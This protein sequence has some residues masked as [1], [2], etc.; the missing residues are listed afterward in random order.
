MSSRLATENVV[1]T[2]TL[3]AG[4]G[5]SGGGASGGGEDGGEPGGDSGGEPGGDEEGSPD[6]ASPEAS[7]PDAASPEAS[8][9]DPVSLVLAVILLLRVT[10]V[11]L[12]PLVGAGIEEVTMA[13][14]V[15]GSMAV[16]DLAAAARWRIACVIG[17]IAMPV[18]LRRDAAHPLAA[19]VARVPSTTLNFA[20]HSSPFSG[21]CVRG[22]MAKEHRGAS[23]DPQDWSRAAS[24]RCL[25]P[26]SRLL[27][28]W[29]RAAG[30]GSRRRCCR[31][32]RIAAR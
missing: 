4:R 9:P 2:V 19:T 15:A 18:G 1:G 20:L 28:G 10:F 32:A 8:S 24:P 31:L 7:S 21:N 23:R 12:V 29:R 26:T 25:R 11:V 14:A 3:A 22:S 27:G 17:S 30:V 6:A 16:G 13:G 5:A